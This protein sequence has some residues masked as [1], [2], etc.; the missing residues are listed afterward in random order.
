M[1]RKYL[2][3]YEYCSIVF[4]MECF[5]KENPNCEYQSGNL[6]LFY[7]TVR[8]SDACR[9]CKKEFPI[10]KIKFYFRFSFPRNWGQ[11]LFWSHLNALSC[12]SLNFEQRTAS[13]ISMP[14]TC[15]LD[16]TWRRMWYLPSLTQDPR[17]DGT[18]YND[19]K[20]VRLDFLKLTKYC[21]FWH[22]G[23]GL[24]TLSCYYSFKS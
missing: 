6:W 21:F 15:F 14:T 23:V 16:K 7:C 2:L 24:L 3:N 11:T 17:E 13:L 8:K 20:F 10:K 1:G 5:V 12:L 22:M 4:I 18:N 19:K 9:D